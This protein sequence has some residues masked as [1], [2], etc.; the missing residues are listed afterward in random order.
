MVTFDQRGTGRSASPPEK[1][2]SY[3]LW[4]YVSDLESVRETV[5][6][7][8]VHLLGHSW[9]G[10]VAMRYATVYP[11]RLRSMVLVGS[12]P[13]TWEGI[14]EGYSRFQER[15]QELQQTGIIPQNLQQE[16]SYAID[17]DGN[18]GQFTIIAPETPATREPVAALPVESATNW[19]LIGG[20]IAACVVV[21]AGVLGYFLVWRKRSSPK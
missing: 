5:G 8:S 15:V 11:E 18:T 9:G 4:E 10:I 2:S 1:V 3:V 6:A 19:G 21:A 14:W 17:I 7:E 20:L 13:P 16:G 12:G